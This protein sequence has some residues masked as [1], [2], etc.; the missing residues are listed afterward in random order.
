[1][2]NPTILAAGILGVSHGLLKRVADAGAAAVTTKTITKEPR[3][4]YANPVFANLGFGYIN[5][6]GL[7]NPGIDQFREEVVKVKR[8]LDIPVIGS[9]GGSDVKEF[10]YV[11][12]QLVRAGVDVI[13]LNLSCPHV[14]G[15]G[16]EVGTDP[17]LTCEI[18]EGVKDV[19]PRP[20]FIKV[21][22]ETKLRDVEKYV[23]VGADGITAINTVRALAIEP[24]AMRPILTNVF[25]GLSGPCIRP[26]AVRV[27][28]EI[29][30]EFPDL[31]IIGVGGV[32]GWRCALEFILAGAT[33]VGIGS[34]LVKEDLKIFGEIVNGLRDFLARRGFGSI[35]DLIGRA[36]P[37]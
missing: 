12:D 13:E 25:G 23:G 36:H 1:L 9:V 16:L 17:A 32:G 29:H 5:A 22:S 6:L 28:Y 24:E 3:R 30:R 34:C 37:R 26:I 7:P 20:V 14:G 33:A 35:K 4:G 19:S 2:T 8:V 27:V 31:P 11:A 15:F 21:S 10:V 18:I